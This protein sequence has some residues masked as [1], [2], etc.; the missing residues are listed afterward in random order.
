MNNKIN[1]IKYKILIIAIILSISLF[2]FNTPLYA[3]SGLNRV[4]YRIDSGGS[5]IKNLRLKANYKLDEV[6]SADTEFTYD[7]KSINIE[8]AWLLNFWNKNNYNFD[9]KLILAQSLKGNSWGKGIGLSGNYTDQNYYFMDARYFIEKDNKFVIEGGLALPLVS[10]SKLSVGLG[11]SY[12]SSS[13]Y[14]L[15]VGLLMEM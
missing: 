8:G 10:S 11:N 3:N 4:H 15:S 9:L 5:D 6:N 7:S 13:D 2:I 1:L 14:T 12:W